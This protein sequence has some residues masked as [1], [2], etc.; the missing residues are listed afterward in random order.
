MRE[1]SKDFHT[2][3]LIDVSGISLRELDDLPESAVVSALREL[4]DS[5]LSPNEF[6]GSFEA[7][8]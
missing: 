3:S 6:V 7:R 8:I 4:L 5:G 2:S 1:E